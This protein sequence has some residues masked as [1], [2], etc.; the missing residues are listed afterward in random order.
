M[1]QSYYFDL[2]QTRIGV[3]MNDMCHICFFCMLIWS[4][5]WPCCSTCI[6][7]HSAYRSNIVIYSSFQCSAYC[8]YVNLKWVLNVFNITPSDVYFWTIIELSLVQS[9]VWW[10]W[11]TSQ[12]LDITHKFKW[13][14]LCSVKPYGMY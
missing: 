8:R 6:N 1:V 2:T 14:V 7:L 10:L 4:H 12:I 11:T 5:S 9:L 3:N 13:N